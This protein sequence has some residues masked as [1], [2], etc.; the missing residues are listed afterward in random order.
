MSNHPDPSLAGSRRL[1]F[2]VGSEHYQIFTVSQNASDASIYFSAPKF[3][4]ITWLVPV[5][6]AK[7]APVLMSFQAS[8]PGK[9]SLHGSGVTHVKPHDGNDPNGFIIRGNILKNSET[10]TLGMR[11]LATIFM[12]EPKHKPSSP[13]FARASDWTFRAT[14]MQPLVVVFWAV[15]LASRL[16]IAIEG[17]FHVDDL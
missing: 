10:A 1:F 8:G 3:E 7:S 11:H 15:P 13:A 4:D 16:N 2:E 14:T 5:L 9:L 12:S 6:D 17:S